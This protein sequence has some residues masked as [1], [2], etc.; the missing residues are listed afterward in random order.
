MSIG[1]AR[2]NERETFT[3]ACFLLWMLRA[4]GIGKFFEN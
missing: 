4:E 1:L 3:K 2:E